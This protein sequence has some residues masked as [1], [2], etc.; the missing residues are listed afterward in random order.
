L[1]RRIPRRGQIAADADQNHRPLSLIALG[2][3]PDLSGTTLNDIFDL[4]G[5]IDDF[6]SG[7]T[8]RHIH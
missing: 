2:L 5:V 8:Y 4:A 6:L 1:R 7:R 3:T